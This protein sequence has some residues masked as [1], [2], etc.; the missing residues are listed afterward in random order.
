MTATLAVIGGSGAYHLLTR[1]RLGEEVDCASRS[2]PFGE[3]APLHEFRYGEQ[4]FLFL[5][6]HGETDYSLTAPFVNYRANIYALKDCGI[7]R[8]VAWSGPG[9]INRAFRPGEFVLPHDV[10][11]ETKNRESTFFKGRGVGFI[12]QSDPFCP[13]VRGALHES[14]H[15]SGLPHHEEGVYVCTQGPRLESPAEIRKFRIIGADLVGMTLCPEAFLARELE[16]CYALVCYLTNYAEG[17]VERDFKKGELFEGMQSGEEKTQVEAAV[18]RFP[19]IIAG[20]FAQLMNRTPQCN[21]P[22][23]LQR[24]RDKGMIGGDWREWVGPP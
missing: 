23:A 15:L 13:E 11:D 7:Q 1:N 14:M 12:R 20:A 6:R 2:T 4:S 19:E 17:V 5:S 21:C 9:I 24:Y 18:Q 3:S 10:I 22:H 8:I 16:M